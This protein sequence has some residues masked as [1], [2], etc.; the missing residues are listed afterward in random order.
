MLPKLLYYNTHHSQIIH[1][2]HSNKWLSNRLEKN[3]NTQTRHSSTCNLAY[4]C[5]PSF[6]SLPPIVSSLSSRRPHLCVV[7]M[8]IKPLLL[9]E[10]CIICPSQEQ[11]QQIRKPPFFPH[12]ISLSLWGTIS[13]YRLLKNYIPLFHFSPLYGGLK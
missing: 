9:I 3:T 1:L 7:P 13:S 5:L 10:N 4:T 2:L 11:S 8:S 12:T 6:L